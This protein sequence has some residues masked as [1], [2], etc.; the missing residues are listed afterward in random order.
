MTRV[1]RWTMPLLAMLCL[2]TMAQDVL[3]LNDAKEGNGVA[4]LQPHPDK[5]VPNTKTC[6]FDGAQDHLVQGQRT[7]VQIFN[8]KFWTDYTITIDAVTQIQSGP[9]IRNLNEAESL[10]LGPASFASV[11]P[12]KGGAEGLTARTT[13]KIL[14]DLIDETRATGAYAD[15][16]SDHEVIER[17]R[18]K[19][20][21][22]LKDFREHYILLVGDPVSP[23]EV[24]CRAATGAPN[25]EN[26]SACFKKELAIEKLEPWCCGERYSDEP[27][28]LVLNTRVQDLIAALKVL[29]GQLAATDLPTKLQS[30]ATAIAQYENDLNVFLANAEAAYDAALL[31]ENMQSAARKKLRREQLKVLLL[32]KLKGSDS[33]PVLDDAEMN[34]LLDGFEHAYANVEDAGKK[35]PADMEVLKHRWKDLRELAQN[36][37]EVLPRAGKFRSGLEA[38][39]VDLAVNLPE[40]VNTLNSTQGQVLNRVNY[41]YDHSEVQEPL[42]KQIDLSGHSGNLIVYYTIRRIENFQRYTVAQVQEPGSSA[43]ANQAGIPLPP[44]KGAAPATSAAQPATAST[45]ST[46]NSATPESNAANA[47]PSGGTQSTAA[48]PQGVVAAR[49]SFEVHDVFHANVV[50]AVAF[51]TLKD[52]TITKQAQPTFC[53]GTSAT[54]DSNCFAPL[55]NNSSYKWAPIVGLDYYLRPRDTF[56]RAQSQPWLCREDWKQCVGFMGAASA[57]KANN[58]FVGGFFEPA[59]GVQFA[60]G[61]NFGTKTVLDSN[62]K[63]GTPADITGDFPTH[64]ARGTG[65][66]F[67]AGLDLGIFRKIFGKFTGIGTAASGTSGQ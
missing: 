16:N 51:S 9:N 7:E 15:L 56:P 11:P 1:A 12:S 55:L 28:F 18:A 67:S 17:E 31:A 30:L 5:P 4:C 10:T 13:D 40:A 29:A 14:F 38:A 47:S 63:V 36:Y 34:A 19:L 8:R 42:T 52:Q 6:P 24:D 48:V 66:F 65:F 25:I 57:I 43:A 26:I 44:A 39:R 58:Y 54:P 37:R 61:A 21:A 35:Q 27:S 32:D 49:G 64:D 50:A 60:T 46:A 2:R 62:Y 33:K 45:G 53:T 59:L 41:I 22:Q 20:K 23:D 3:V